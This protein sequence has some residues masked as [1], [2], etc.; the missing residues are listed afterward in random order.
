MTWA[1]ITAK[2]SELGYHQ[3]FVGLCREVWVR[4]GHTVN[5]AGDRGG[6][7]AWDREPESKRDG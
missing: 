1:D 7:W 2:L 4:A 6:R 5:I 3:Q